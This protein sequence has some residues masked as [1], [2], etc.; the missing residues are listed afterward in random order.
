MRPEGVI[1]N[2]GKGFDENGFPICNDIANLK[3]DTHRDAMESFAKAMQCGLDGH[4]WVQDE[5]EGDRIECSRCGQP[6]YQ[7]Q[8][9]SMFGKIKRLLRLKN[10]WRPYMAGVIVGI[11][12]PVLI[13]LGYWLVTK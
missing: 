1:R 13:I 8:E 11:L 10:W 12:I 7:E 5:S 2:W 3:L 9:L 6:A 4:D